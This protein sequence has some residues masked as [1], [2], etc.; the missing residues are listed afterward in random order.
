MCVSQRRSQK[1][2]LTPTQAPGPAPPEPGPAP[3][4]LE[5]PLVTPAPASGTTHTSIPPLPRPLR[6][7]GSRSSWPREQFGATEDSLMLQGKEFL[8]KKHCPNPHPASRI[9][10]THFGCLLSRSSSETG[11]HLAVQ[12]LWSIVCVS[13]LPPSS[14]SQS[15]RWCGEVARDEVGCLYPGVQTPRA[16][17]FTHIISGKR[18]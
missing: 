15:S 13:P 12:K 16:G 4:S 17:N 9:C 8:E 18:A 6:G 5:G 7:G 14:I 1:A 3:C 11:S 2:H 10:S